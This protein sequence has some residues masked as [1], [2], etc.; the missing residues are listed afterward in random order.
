MIKNMDT[1]C[2]KT[3]V[4]SERQSERERDS[5][6]YRCSRTRFNNGICKKRDGLVLF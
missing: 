5:G 4:Q 6:E 2:K 3:R 1:F